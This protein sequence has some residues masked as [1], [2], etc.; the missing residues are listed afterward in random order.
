[1]SRPL[2]TVPRWTSRVTAAWRSTLSWMR[3]R[4]RRELR[5]AQERELLLE[6][7]ALLVQQEV[8]ALLLQALR[9]LAQ[10]LERQ[11]SLLLQ[12]THRLEWKAETAEE[13]LLELLQSQ[14]TPASLMQ[15]ELGIQSP[16]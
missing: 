1:V 6:Q 5:R 15:Q 14:P 7:M 4:R 12:E 10:A 9:P 16:T 2:T 8:R 13:M 3:W 11:D